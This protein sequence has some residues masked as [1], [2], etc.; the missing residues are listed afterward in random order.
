MCGDQ[1]REKFWL[2]LVISLGVTIGS[3]PAGRVGESGLN[4]GPG[5]NFSLKLTSLYIHRHIAN[6]IGRVR[7][8]HKK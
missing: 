6:I 3:A 2:G 8:D 7:E 1:L 5:E 4:H